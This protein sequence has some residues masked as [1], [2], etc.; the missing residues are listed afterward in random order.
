MA[1]VEGPVVGE[2]APIGSYAG[3]WGIDYSVPVGTAVHAPASGRVTFAGSVAGMR[4]VTIEP[5]PGLK[6][7]VSYLS[8]I[9]V[10]S[11]E[12]VTRGDVVGSAGAPHG[13]EGVHLSTRI[14][15]GYVDP[16]TQLGCRATDITRALRL[17]TPPGPY[18]RKRAHRDLR[19]DVRPDPYRPPPRRGDGDLPGL[20]GPGV[21]HAGRR[22]L[23]KGPP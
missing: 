20:A 9:S 7:S 3:H 11:G 21:V 10:V 8:G 13:R 17:V 6:V 14:D 5:V 1:P 22:P 19:W 2:Y 12:T 4:S 23:A 15:S 16:E 18:P